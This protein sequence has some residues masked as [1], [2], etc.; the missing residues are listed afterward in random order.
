[1]I[2]RI[3]EIKKTTMGCHVLVYSI[4]T[5]V[6][7]T[8]A[9]CSSAPNSDGKSDHLKSNIATAQHF[10]SSKSSTWSNAKTG[11]RLTDLAHTEDDDNEYLN[12]IIKALSLSRR[13]RDSSEESDAESEVE[14]ES[15]SSTSESGSEVESEMELDYPLP[16]LGGNLTN[17]S[18]SR[19]KHSGTLWRANW[20]LLPETII[21]TC[22][23]LHGY[24]MPC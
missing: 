22:L 13:R 23:V 3:S 20:G 18:N 19:Y 4:C 14:S 6:F 24:V 10:R 15:E 2:L 1:M 5:L 11:L 16:H 21:A 7:Y 17:G 12:H 9:V 8:Y